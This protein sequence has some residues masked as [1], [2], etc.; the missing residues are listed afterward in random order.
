[1]AQIK[2]KKELCPQNHPC[3]VAR[4]CPVGAI[5]QDNPYSAPR[6]IEAQCKHCGICTNFCPVFQE[7][8]A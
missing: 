5:K 6:I 4:R 1:M 7:V 3:P 2:I 8:A